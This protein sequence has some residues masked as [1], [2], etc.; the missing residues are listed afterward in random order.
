MNQCR[1]G[2]GRGGHRHRQITIQTEVIIHARNTS[3]IYSLFNTSEGFIYKCPAAQEGS[4]YKHSK[5]SSCHCCSHGCKGTF[6]N[7]KQLQPNHAAWRVPKTVR[8]PSG[9]SAPSPPHVHLLV[10]RGGQ[11]WR[12]LGWERCSGGVHLTPSTC[13]CM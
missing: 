11:S 4:A 13:L 3:Q 10:L 7:F 9:R 2:A 1:Y 5:T 8:Q 12:E 6:P